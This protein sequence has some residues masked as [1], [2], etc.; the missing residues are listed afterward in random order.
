MSE[1]RRYYIKGGTWFFTVNLRNRRSQLLTTQ[2]QM[3]RH[4]IIKV[5]RDRLLK[6]TPGSFC[7]S[8]CTVSGHYLKAMMIFPRA[9]GKLKSNLPMLV[10]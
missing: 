8:I 7:Q 2:Y 6:S 1:Y 4:A 5:K 9:G 10:D 3:L